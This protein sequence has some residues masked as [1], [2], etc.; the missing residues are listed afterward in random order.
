[1]RFIKIKS[2][3]K[4]NLSLGIL[5][6][7]KSKL[8]RIE[9][10]VTFIDLYD[11]ILVKRIYE[12]KNKVI[13][14][15][16]FSNS[17]PK[18]NSITKLLDILEK[19]KFLKEE[20][21]L[22]KIKKNIPQKSGMGGGSMNAA[23]ILKYFIK[24]KKIFL[25]SDQIL[26]ITKN[27]GSDVILGMEKK[28]KILSKNGKIFILNKKFKLFTLII[29]PDFGCE[30]KK[31]YQ[32]CKLYSKPKLYKKE[33]SIYK[34]AK[35][36]NDLEKIAF[37]KYPML[38]SIKNYMIKLPNVKFVRMTGSGSALIGYFFSKKASLNASKLLRR[39][40]KNYWCILSKTI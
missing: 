1:M 16:K 2:Y 6:K 20:K 26:D 37:K 36:K 39:K 9:S 23:S 34:I 19:K 10:L 13:F 38:L 27:I 33:L 28:N 29:M 5:G 35:L 12:K 14:S 8:H 3:A 11:E 21:Y 17:I 25:N 40:Y 7:L 31:I 4:I 30:T 22:F 18:K 32:L 15:G 24:K